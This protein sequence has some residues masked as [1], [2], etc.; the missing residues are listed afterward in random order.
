LQ[1]SDFSI[2]IWSWTTGKIWNS[3]TSSRATIVSIYCRLSSIV[4]V[5]RL[6]P[7]IDASHNYIDVYGALKCPIMLKQTLE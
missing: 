1:D 2:I 3:M 4:I 6:R 7:D 5:M